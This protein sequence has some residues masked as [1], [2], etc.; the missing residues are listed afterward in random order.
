M[1]AELA[2]LDDNASVAAA[3]SRWPVVLARL[4]DARPPAWL[5]PQ[6][7]SWQAVQLAAIDRQVSANRQRSPPVTDR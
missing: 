1:N 4:L 5:P 7:A 3:T 6:Y 2:K